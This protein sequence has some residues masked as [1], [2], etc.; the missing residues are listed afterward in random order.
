MSFARQFESQRPVIEH[1]ECDGQFPD[2]DV[3]PDLG[4]AAM[5]GITSVGM[6][7]TIISD[8]K[9]L[10]NRN[11]WDSLDGYILCLSRIVAKEIAW[12]CI[13][14]SFKECKESIPQKY[15]KA[16]D[17]GSGEGRSISDMAVT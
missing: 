7:E 15:F 4:A 10:L 13:T 5:L 14:E 6:V 1:P 11:Q 17:K 12:K 3:S 8:V 2:S 9:E 16:F